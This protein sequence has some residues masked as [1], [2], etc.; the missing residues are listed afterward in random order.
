MHLLCTLLWQK[1][2]LHLSKNT[3]TP[4]QYVPLII[5]YA[6]GTPLARYDGANNIEE[7]NFDG[8]DCCLSLINNLHCTECFC[9]EDES[10]HSIETTTY[11]PDSLHGIFF[12]CSI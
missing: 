4:I 2:I 11:S 5:L 1:S 6:N 12:Q 7:C 9:F 3:L 10:Y 8:G